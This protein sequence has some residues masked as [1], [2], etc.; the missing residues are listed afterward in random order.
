[1]ITYFADTES[2]V[3]L[4]GRASAGGSVPTLG[5]QES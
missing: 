1:M 4:M 3:Q 5:D 2:V